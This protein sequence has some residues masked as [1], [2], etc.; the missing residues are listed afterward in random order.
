MNVMLIDSLIAL[1]IST[2]LLTVVLLL[3][4]IPYVDYGFRK[5]RASEAADRIVSELIN[6]GYLD[7]I[8]RKIELDKL[9]DVKILL[10]HVHQKY[11]ELVYI[12]IIA[13]KMIIEAGNSTKSYDV[14]LLF[15]LN[16]NVKVIL[17]VKP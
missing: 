15:P 10:E 11:D 1:I 12:A 13:N 6:C 17:R 16:D 3:N 5:L 8:L 9:S 7:L 2:I 4:P 14:E